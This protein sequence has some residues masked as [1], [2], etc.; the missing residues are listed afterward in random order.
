RSPLVV[1]DHVYRLFDNGTF[2][3]LELATGKELYK[4]RVP[5]LTSVWASPVADGAGRIFLASGGTSVVVEAGP[6]FKVLAT[7]KLNDPNH[8]SPAVAGGRLYLV[9]AKRLYAVGKK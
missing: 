9:G 4:E 2:A 6:E 1:D 7:N 5:G 8:A 3:C